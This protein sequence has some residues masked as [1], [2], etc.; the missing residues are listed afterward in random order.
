MENLC[1]AFATLRHFGTLSQKGRVK[2]TQIF[3]SEL[4]YTQSLSLD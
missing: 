2:Q 4:T 3:S 1:Q